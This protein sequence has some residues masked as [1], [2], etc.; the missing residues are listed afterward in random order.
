MMYKWRCPGCGKTIDEL[1]HVVE[2]GSTL[3]ECGQYFCWEYIRCPDE[4][5]DDIPTHADGETFG[6]MYRRGCSE[7]YNTGYWV[8]M[9]KNTDLAYEYGYAD[10]VA[11]GEDM[12]APT[13]EPPEYKRYDK[14]GRSGMFCGRC[15]TVIYQHDPDAEITRC[16]RCPFCDGAL[17]WVIDGNCAFQP[18]RLYDQNQVVK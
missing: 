8:G 5:D 13:P 17:F 1:E 6:V 12:L 10:G 7:A 18:K 2:R 14:D 16:G 15:D 11:E 3:C 9:D 4:S